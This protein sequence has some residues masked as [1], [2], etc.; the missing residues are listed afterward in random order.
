[1]Y[2]CTLVL[3]AFLT[4]HRR[5]LFSL[6]RPGLYSQPLR[7]ACSPRWCLV[8]LVS[9]PPLPQW[10]TGALDWSDIP[11]RLQSWGLSFRLHQSVSEKIW[12]LHT[13]DWVIVGSGSSFYLCNPSFLMVYAVHVGSGSKALAW[14]LFRKGV[15][16]ATKPFSYSVFC[17]S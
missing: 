3:P 15:R 2:Y 5:W 1:M 13:S 16:G 12:V 4:L 9:K 11:A 8:K 10:V 17:H 6:W 14:A 7:F